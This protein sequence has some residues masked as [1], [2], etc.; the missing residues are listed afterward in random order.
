[1]NIFLERNTLSNTLS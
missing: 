1:M